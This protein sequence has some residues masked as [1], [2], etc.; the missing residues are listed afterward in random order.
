MPNQLQVATRGRRGRAASLDGPHRKRGDRC[1]PTDR[2]PWWASG[3]VSPQSSAVS[4][5][6][7]L[8]LALAGA[9]GP[10]L[11][12]GMAVRS[13]CPP[14]NFRVHSCYSPFLDRYSHHFRRSAKGS[15]LPSALTHRSTR[16]PILCNKT[17]KP[18][19]PP[20]PPQPTQTQTPGRIQKVDPLKG[21]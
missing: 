11:S 9:C 12:S 7:R 17:R 4:A 5:S 21:S 3:A 2:L 13:P 18:K 6:N 20:P 16:T 19:T 8:S 10:R 1:S 15:G 14:D